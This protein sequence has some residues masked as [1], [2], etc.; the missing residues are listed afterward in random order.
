M[1][2]DMLIE[3]NFAVFE[4]QETGMMV[5]VQSYDN[6]CFEVR[7]GT[8]DDSEYVGEVQ[9]NSSDELNLNLSTLFYSHLKELKQV[10]DLQNI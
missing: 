1:K 2:F 9:A 4:N 5:Y 6:Q 3:Q 10:D 7:I 8:I